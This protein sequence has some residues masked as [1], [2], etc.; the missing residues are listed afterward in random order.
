MFVHTYI[1]LKFSY[2]VDFI[3]IFLVKNTVKAFT[4][5]LKL[6]AQHTFHRSNCVMLFT[7]AIENYT[8]GTLTFLG[9]IITKS[10]NGE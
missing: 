10:H 9:V 2:S 5:T 3:K 4:K 1:S 6:Y 8:P 7:H